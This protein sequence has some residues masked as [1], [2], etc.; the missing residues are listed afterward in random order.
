[1]S[2][3]IAYTLFLKVACTTWNVL[4]GMGSAILPKSH[5][6]SSKDLLQILSRNLGIQTVVLRWTHSTDRLQVA[7]PRIPVRANRHLSRHVIWALVIDNGIAQP[8]PMI[9]D[10]GIHNYTCNTKHMEGI[11]TW[12]DVLSHYN[13]RLERSVE[14]D[15]DP[16]TFDDDELLRN[17]RIMV[18]KITKLLEKI[19]RKWSK[20]M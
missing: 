9:K 20:R 8:M 18:E 2:K 4:I 3:K 11:K 10:Q 15:S 19:M 13:S 1:M 5:K 7:S 14:N 12:V 16:W 6:I 17:S